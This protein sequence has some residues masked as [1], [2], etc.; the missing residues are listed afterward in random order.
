VRKR[1]KKGITIREIQTLGR[2][3]SSL[4]LCFQLIHYF[5]RCLRY[6]SAT[7]SRFSVAA[8][9]AI[10]P[11]LCLSMRR[12][13]S[14][15]NRSYSLRHSSIRIRTGLSWSSLSSTHRGT[16]KAT[17]NLYLVLPQTC[18]ITTTLSLYLLIP[19]QMKRPLDTIRS[20]A[21]K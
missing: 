17:L 10:L 4:A 15:K 7:N 20:P 18:M 8:S 21:C 3:L 19:S 11:Y 1:L 2:P 14:P 16:T 6:K 5:G 9:P 13:S 12:T